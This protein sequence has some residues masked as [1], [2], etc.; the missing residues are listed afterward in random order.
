LNKTVLITGGNKGIGLEV[1][2]QFLNLEYNI[3]I[4]AR[5]FKNFKF[6]NNSKIKQ[7]EFDLSKIDDIP[8]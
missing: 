6:K 5:D 1:T 2:K 4:I 7:I 3:I 8:N